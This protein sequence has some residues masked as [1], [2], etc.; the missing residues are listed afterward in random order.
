M[1]LFSTFVHFDC[2]GPEGLFSGASHHFLEANAFRQD[3]GLNARD[4]RSAEKQKKCR[5]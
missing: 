1:L 3:H 4:P 2:L 5:F